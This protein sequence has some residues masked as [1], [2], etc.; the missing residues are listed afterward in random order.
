MLQP[1]RHQTDRKPV[2]PP[3]PMRSLAV[4]AARQSRQQLPRREFVG[5][6][7]HTRAPARTFPWRPPARVWLLIPYA[8]STTQEPGGDC[9]GPFRTHPATEVDRAL[10]P[11]L[12]R[13][14]QT[15]G[16]SSDAELGSPRI[17]P[18]P[19]ASGSHTDE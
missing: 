15:R 1:D 5:L 13:A 11:P 19:G 4:L 6:R 12:Q 10:L 7:K 17:R 14:W 8:V 2:S 3:K 18:I 16:T 9:R